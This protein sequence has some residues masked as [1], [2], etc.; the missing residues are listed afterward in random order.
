MSLLRLL[1]GLLVAATIVV[2]AL[3]LVLGPWALA[4]RN[5]ITAWN[6]YAPPAVMVPDDELAPAPAF[7]SPARCLLEPPQLQTTP[8]TSSSASASHRV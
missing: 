7:A 3:A 5:D 8:G 4:E 6:I 2:T 1:F